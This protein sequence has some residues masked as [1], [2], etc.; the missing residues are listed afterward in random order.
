MKVAAIVFVVGCVLLLC[1]AV[2]AVLV[3]FTR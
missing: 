3:V 2:I 1:A